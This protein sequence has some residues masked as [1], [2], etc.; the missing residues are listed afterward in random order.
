MRL[1]PLEGAAALSLH[2]VLDTTASEAGD[3]PLTLSSPD[4][5]SRVF[6]AAVKGDAD[7]VVELLALKLL[8]DASESRPGEP[9]TNGARDERFRKERQYTKTLS[10]MGPGFPRLYGLEL[11]EKEGG[12]LPP[13]LYH[14]GLRM[15]FRTPSPR[16][17]FLATC[18]D[19]G[20]L[21]AHGLPS[22]EGS[23]ERFLWDPAAPEDERVFYG[24]GPAR[25]NV[26]TPAELVAELDAALDAGVV[27]LPGTD[28]SVRLGKA[29]RFLS[30][31][32]GPFL[33][34]GLSA[35]T[36]EEF[37]DLAGGRPWESLRAVRGGP[38]V[39]PST[40]FRHAVFAS[41]AS[42]STRTLFS[43][44][45][46]GLD[47]VEALAL[48]LTAFRQ[49][50]RSLITFG[51]ATSRPHLDVHP[52]HL[53]VDLYGGGDG[54]PALW[55]FQTRLHGLSAGGR[56]VE[57]QGFEELAVPP[58]APAVPY[59]SP[60]AQEFRL[61]GTRPCEVILA[62]VNESARGVELEGRLVDPYGL[63]PAPTPNDVLVLGLHDATLDLGVTQA[64]ARLRPRA[65]VTGSEITFQTSP[66]PLAEGATQ[67]LRRTIGVRLPATTYKVYSDFRATGDFHALGVLLLRLLVVNDAQDIASVTQELTRFFAPHAGRVKQPADGPALVTLARGDAAVGPIL[68]RPAVFFEAEDRRRGRP[69]AIPEVLWDR[70]LLLAF[71]L[72]SKVP[73]LS[74]SLAG[75]VSGEGSFLD[76]LD[77]VVQE[78]EAITKELESVLFSR[79][80]LHLEIQQVLGEVWLEELSPSVAPPRRRV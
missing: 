63:Y 27:S 54:L 18:R 56:V 38:S 53:L 51:K 72:F 50:A 24:T 10:A 65:P 7:T 20:V 26:R 29:A 11:G 39:P 57:L 49:V 70:A 62:E 23:L 40:R 46:S 8:T 71:R 28:G 44:E 35:L 73:G 9:D 37:S 61:A 69:N 58:S 55:C 14:R 25:A 1:F 21:S 77:W 19:E 36:I 12:L 15:L 13:L 30:F 22:Y 16:G 64:T 68:A 41:H 32:D 45:G 66:L 48:K 43:A 42:A 59:A 33:L 75:P 6:V 52:R 34:T 2:L 79:Q 80:G 67:R 31:Y 78:T 76:R 3:E 17:G 47:A 5:T 74:L 4:E 60:E